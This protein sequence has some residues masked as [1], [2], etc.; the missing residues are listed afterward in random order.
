MAAQNTWNLEKNIN[1]L[2]NKISLLEKQFQD[3]K[4]EVIQNSKEDLGKMHDYVQTH[5]GLVI[6]VVALMLTGAAL[7]G[8][9][10][11]RK[12]EKNLEKI[13][14]IKLEIQAL[15][16]KIEWELSEKVF[17][18]FQE[19]EE[20]YIFQRL[21]SYDLGDFDHFF[22]RLATLPL[23]KPEK[24]WVLMNLVDRSTED[25]ISFIT[26]IFQ[27]F[28]E[29]FVQDEKFRDIFVERLECITS[30]YNSE[31]IKWTQKI[32]EELKKQKNTKIEEILQIWIDCIK[33]DS[34]YDTE[35]KEPVRVLLAEAIWL[36]FEK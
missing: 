26:L 25:K 24:Y 11:N 5:D 1:E 31:I 6:G 33:K 32:Y 22:P 2:N 9:L 36:N 18:K 13:E 29:K 19:K 8:I 7:I 23:L 14:K 20:D 30:C 35:L 3:Y 10:W 27:F 4:V 28:P 12:I 17:R 34:R 21:E 16:E 15:D